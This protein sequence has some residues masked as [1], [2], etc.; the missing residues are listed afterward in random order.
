MSRMNMA[1][2][3]F[4]MAMNHGA[5]LAQ[6]EN[7]RTN[8]DEDVAREVAG[9]AVTALAAGLKKLPL[10]VDV[11]YNRAFDVLRAVS[12]KTIGSYSANLAMLSM[13]RTYDAAVIAGANVTRM[14]Q[15]DI[16][17]C[18]MWFDYAAWKEKI[19]PERSPERKENRIPSCGPATG[20]EI[21]I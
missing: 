4:C 17:A 8:E 14:I 7:L 5:V 20:R 19:S 12:S 2:L 16:D 9:C 1:A 15:A 18:Q 3:A 21:S 11:G 13:A 10:G 6:E